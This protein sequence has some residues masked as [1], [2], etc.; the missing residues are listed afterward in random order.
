MKT[1][2]IGAGIC[3]LYLGLKLSEKGNKID[4]FERKEKAG[5]NVVRSGLFSERILDFIP[6]SKNL[7]ENR[8]KFVL[9]HFPKKT[10]RVEFSKDFLVMSHSKLDQLVFEMAKKSGTNIIFNKNINELPEGYDNIIG[11]DGFDSLTRKKSCQA[12]PSYRIGIQGFVNNDDSLNG[13][14]DGV[15]V[16]PLETKDGFIWKIPRG[17]EIEYGIIG[18]PV[19]SISSFENFLAK[20]NINL[21]KIESK[22]IPMGILVSD[23]PLIALC[24]DAAGMTKPWSGGGVIWGITA[25]N[26]L[27]KAYPNLEKYNKKA[28]SFFKWKFKRS[29]LLTKTVYF[30]GFKFPWILP[31]KASIESDFLL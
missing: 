31:N 2:I 23:N 12:S 16:W 15:E 27:V 10:V 29:Q 3:G 8:I 5:D 7:I 25:A 28:Y 9:I 22:L 30:L 18:N 19:S 4:I 14:S 24:G 20:N 6:E 11:C 13:I 21:T 17:K 26:I 1:A